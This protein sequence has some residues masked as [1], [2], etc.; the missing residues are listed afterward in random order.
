MCRGYR[1]SFGRDGVG[2][3]SES[4]KKSVEYSRRGVNRLHT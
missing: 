4:A 2:G 3:G 1:K